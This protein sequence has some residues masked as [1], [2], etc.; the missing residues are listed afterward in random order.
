VLRTGMY[1]CTEY[2][3][4]GSIMLRKM[5]TVDLVHAGQPYIDKHIDELMKNR[6]GDEDFAIGRLLG[7]GS[8]G[9]V[10]QVGGKFVLKI[11]RTRSIDSLYS[12]ENLCR[13]EA[14]NIRCVRDA[15]KHEMLI[16]LPDIEEA[17]LEDALL[18]SPQGARQG[19]SAKAFEKLILFLKEVI[20]IFIIHTY[21]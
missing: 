21:M 9:D 7:R 3:S 13:V 5:L 4:P 6:S 12:A 10:Y 18:M 19:G 14:T 16:H 15:L 17:I 1:E 2:A 8:C 11:F 20:F